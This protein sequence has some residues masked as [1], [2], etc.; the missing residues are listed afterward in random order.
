MSQADIDALAWSLNNRIKLRLPDLPPLE[1]TPI[2]DT[3]TVLGMMGSYWAAARYL[4]DEGGW[5]RVAWNGAFMSGFWVAW[6]AG[7]TDAAEMAVDI[8]SPWKW[9]LVAKE[10]EKA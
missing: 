3:V 8:P 4:R 6:P 9:S 10:T 5:V 2:G 7:A 1:S